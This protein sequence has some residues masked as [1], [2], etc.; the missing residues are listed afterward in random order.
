[1]LYNILQ[2]R[3]SERLRDF[4]I[5]CQRAIDLPTIEYGCNGQTDKVTDDKTHCAITEFEGDKVA[6]G[7][8][9]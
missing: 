5:V 2:I 7:D 3:L 4:A 8:I 9:E 1:M 6:D